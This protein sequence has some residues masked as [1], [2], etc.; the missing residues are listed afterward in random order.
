MFNIAILDFDKIFM[1]EEALLCLS[2]RQVRQ[3]RHD[4][5]CS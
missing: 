2:L 4:L 5:F 1:A 3:M